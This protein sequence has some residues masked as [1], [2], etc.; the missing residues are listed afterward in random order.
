MYV[1][2]KTKKETMYELK[3]KGLRRIAMRRTI[4]I[5]NRKV[6]TSDTCSLIWKVIAY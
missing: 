3:L 6:E 2:S 5:R 4:P 1:F